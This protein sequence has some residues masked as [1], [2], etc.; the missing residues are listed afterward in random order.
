MNSTCPK[1]GVQNPP[2]MSFCTNCGNSLAAEPQNGGNF[3]N[4]GSSDLPPTMLS[5]QPNLQ[6]NPIA[7]PITPSTQPNAPKKGGKGLM[8]GIIGCG[9]LL[10]LGIIGL[11]IGIVAFGLIDTGTEE[12]KANKNSKNTNSE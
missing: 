3:P 8:F 5:Y 4:T 11:A 10:I 2:N 12:I 9:A 1:C 7:P 6:P